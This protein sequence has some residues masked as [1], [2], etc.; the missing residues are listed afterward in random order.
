MELRI[1]EHELFVVVE[2]FLAL[3][4]RLVEPR[5]VVVVVPV[6]EQARGAGLQQ[7]ACLVDVRERGAPVLEDRTRVPGCGVPGRQVHA[8]AAAG[9]SA[10]ADQPFRLQDPEPLA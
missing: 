3:G 8:G 1:D 7:R 4:Q 2:G 6:G 5:D 10:Y 9:A